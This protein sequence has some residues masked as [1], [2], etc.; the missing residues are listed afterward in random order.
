MREL[1]FQATAVFVFGGLMV[2]C[3]SVPAYR[4]GQDGGNDLASG[5]TGDRPADVFTNGDAATDEPLDT[6]VDAGLDS[7]S[8]TRPEADGTGDAALDVSS[9]MPDGSTD[10]STPNDGAAEVSCTPKCEDYQACVSLR[11]TPVYVSTANLSAGQTMSI[12]AVDLASDGSYYVAGRFQGNVDFNPGPDVDYQVGPDSFPSIFITRFNADASYGWTRTF[13]ADAA[14]GIGDVTG[15][16]VSPDGTVVVA[17][18]FDGTFDFDPGPG[19]D[20]R[21]AVTQNIYIAKLAS[22]GSMP[23]SPMMIEGQTGNGPTALSLDVGAD[24][25]ILLAGFFSGPVDFDPSIG[26]DVRQSVGSPD[27]FLMKVTAQ[28]GYLWT[29]T[30]TTDY[31]GGAAALSPDG[32]VWLTGTFSNARDFDPG[33]GVEIRTPNSNDAFLLR[34][35]SLG[36][37]VDAIV[38]GGPGSDSGTVVTVVDDGTVYLGGAF[39]GTV[40]FD[41]GS[42]VQSRTADNNAGDYVLQLGTDDKFI[43]VYTYPGQGQGPYRLRRAGGEAVL[44]LSANAGGTLSQLSGGSV[45]WSIDLSNDVFPATLAAQGSGFALVGRFVNNVDFDPGA[46]RDSFSAPPAGDQFIS[47]YTF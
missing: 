21:T 27:E 24:G 12:E 44:L 32:T 30:L 38:I 10:S 43:S 28:G 47:R 11:C 34:L 45:A 26:M 22:D 16:R 39:Q 15:L 9:A 42:G 29:R 46:A 8:D 13:V 18:V 4:G 41:P 7:A 23:W 17:G 19:T 40:D 35:N 36:N 6:G 2:A 37:Y 1:K 14:F 20:L 33:P 31:Q 5:A 3:S 25:A